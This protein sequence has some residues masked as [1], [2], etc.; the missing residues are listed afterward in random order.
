[1]EKALFAE[2]EGARYGFDTHDSGGTRIYNSASIDPSIVHYEKIRT[3]G[4]RSP[5]AKRVAVVNGISDILEDLIQ[6]GTYL[7][8]RTATCR[9]ML[10]RAEEK[11]Q[12]PTSPRYA[13][14]IL[15]PPERKSLT[16]FK[17]F[18]LRPKGRKP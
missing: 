7:D 8:E 11:S 2:Y 6:R 18:R 9:K 5:S 4:L 12:T 10:L 17:K 14:R 13:L 15:F 1:M 3:G 16:F